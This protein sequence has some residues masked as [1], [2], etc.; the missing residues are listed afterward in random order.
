MW[1][2][3]RES[4][5]KDPIKYICTC[6]LCCHLVAL[7]D[8][9]PNLSRLLQLAT[10]TYFMTYYWGPVIAGAFFAILLMQARVY[11]PFLQRVT[12]KGEISTV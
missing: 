7:G 10:L 8:S 4:F 1:G 11:L 5:N 12:I 2:V 3:G 9:S 6:K